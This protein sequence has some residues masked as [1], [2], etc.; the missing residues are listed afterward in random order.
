[1]SSSEKVIG[2]AASLLDALDEVLIS[3]EGR[4]G[5]EWLTIREMAEAKKVTTS[6]MNTIMVR[7]M[8][9]GQVERVQRRSGSGAPHYYYRLVT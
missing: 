4:P 7:M 2:D 3:G 1:M 9:R 5:P 6:Y 8:E